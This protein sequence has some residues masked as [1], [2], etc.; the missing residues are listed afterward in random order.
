MS[1]HGTGGWF[2]RRGSR[3]Y[4]PY[5]WDQI[6]EH[7]RAGRIGTRDSLFDPATGAWSR[8]PKVASL[9]GPGGAATGTLVG[10]TAA[11]IA[12]AIV[13]ILATVIG[14]GLALV[15]VN[16][17]STTPQEYLE[18][19]LWSISEAVDDEADSTRVVALPPEG[20]C[21]KGTFDS[22][23]LESASQTYNRSDTC[24]LWVY[25]TE[26]GTYANFSF[27]D[28]FVDGWPGAMQDGPV[29]DIWGEYTFSN[30][31]SLVEVV[32]IEV[33]LDEDSMTE[34]SITNTNDVG[35]FKSG[36]F[37]GG[38]VSYEEYRDAVID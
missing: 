34:G 18:E 29:H 30:P 23:W 22:T 33:G 28:S 20:V 25:A 3:S 37:S 6:V 26:D 4:G 11:K 9:F 7:A 15:F 10:L 1:P 24:Y 2:V 14:I 32:R 27:G 19:S 8:A 35:N 13:L 36:T 21:Y 12:V 31:D 38:R 16:D 5:S 17:S